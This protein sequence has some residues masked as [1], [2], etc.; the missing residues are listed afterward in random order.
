MNNEGIVLRVNDVDIRGGDLFSA[1][2]DVLRQVHE[3]N[4][5]ALAENAIIALMGMEKLS[6]MALAKLL[7]GLHKWWDDTGQDDI[8]NDT[9]EDWIYSVSTQFSPV[10]LGRCVTVW[11]KTETGAFSERI[12]ERP[13]KDQQAIASHLD[14]GYTLGADEWERL[15]DALDN[16]E[17]LSIL[18]ESKGKPPR[19]HSLQIVLERDGSLAVWKEGQKH[20]VGFLN[21]KEA[22]EEEAIEKAINRIVK[23][24]GIK[25]K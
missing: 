5:L 18:R 24:S 14:Q 23:N 22:K 19:K 10:Y 16:A 21:V 15:E 11:D 20:F 9:F 8:T 7:S 4:D 25:V 3:T 2:D 1:V 17:V 13:L 12:Q 6:G